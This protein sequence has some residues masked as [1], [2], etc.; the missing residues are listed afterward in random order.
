MPAPA[1]RFEVPTLEPTFLASITDY[2]TATCRAY[3]VKRTDVVDVV[4]EVLTKIVANIGSFQ[5][6]KGDFDTWA[7]GVALNV[8]RRHLR[9]AKRYGSR[10]SEYH[11]NVDDYATLAPSPERCTQRKQAQCAISNA[12]GKLTQQ[13]VN[14]VVLFDID[15]LPHMEIGNELGITEAASH[16]CHKRARK[17]LAL[18]IDRELL[19][20]MP[21]FLTSCDDSMVNKTGSPWL[22]RSHYVGQ[23]AALLMTAFCLSSLNSSTMHESTVMETRVLDPVQSAVMYRLEKP[24][25]LLDAPNVKPEPASL[26]SVPAVS[27]TTRSADKRTY[28]QDLA[29]LPPYKHDPASDDHLLFGD[30]CP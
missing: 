24:S 16:K 25:V 23:L 19:S 21:P 13:Q 15:D 5:P 14:V 18:C 17:Q 10:F 7:R 6:K 2:I 11:P 8:I 1:Q 4:Q 30:E 27:V 22:E 12:M 20:V 3:H 9:H 28:V 26:P 29:P